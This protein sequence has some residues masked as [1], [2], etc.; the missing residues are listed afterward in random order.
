[1]ATVLRVDKERGLIDLSKKNVVPEEI[2]ECELRYNKGKI[3][4]RILRNVAEDNILYDK[5]QHPF[6]AVT[7]PNLVFEGLY[8]TDEVR[9]NLVQN[10]NNRLTPHEVQIR[11]K[12]VVTCFL[13][14]G[15]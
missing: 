9:Q 12:S 11:A 13:Y 15:L 6:N 14:E 5:Y 10:I 3:V 2:P 7:Q 4:H 1:V 8:M